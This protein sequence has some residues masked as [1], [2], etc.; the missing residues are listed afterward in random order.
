MQGYDMN[1]KF[2]FENAKTVADYVVGGDLGTV[3]LCKVTPAKW[4]VTDMRGYIL[5]TGATRKSCLV[6]MDYL[7]A[8]G[9]ADEIA[10]EAAAAESI[11][12]ARKS[13]VIKDAGEP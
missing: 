2:D 8:R 12:D 3:V 13:V 11:A 6:Q 1:V 5:F 9:R 10:A 7:K 4:H